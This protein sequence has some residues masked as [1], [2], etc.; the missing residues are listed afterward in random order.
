[1]AVRLDGSVASADDDGAEEFFGKVE[2]L[3][4]R[5]RTEPF[6][7]NKLILPPQ[8]PYL[9]QELSRRQDARKE[10][11]RRIAANE[12]TKDQFSLS[13]GSVLSLES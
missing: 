13:S 10:T 12:I 7:V 3:L 11:D 4:I 9:T 8:S 1:M 5:M 2:T 6:P